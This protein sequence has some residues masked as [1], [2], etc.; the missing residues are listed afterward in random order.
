[1]FSVSLFGN[2]RCALAD[3]LVLLHP[4]LLIFVGI[5]ERASTLA[6]SNP[7]RWI[8][9]NLNG[10]K[11]MLH[12]VNRLIDYEIWRATAVCDGPFECWTLFQSNKQQMSLRWLN[13]PFLWQKIS[14]PCVA[15]FCWSKQLGIPC[16]PHQVDL[17]L[18]PLLRQTHLPTCK[19]KG[20]EKLTFLNTG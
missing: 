18:H 6:F 10:W 4:F 3:L 11:A 1:M 17:K 14:V 2:S 13:I 8:T 7:P 20:R 12:R 16:L 9:L 5:Q 15:I 19:V